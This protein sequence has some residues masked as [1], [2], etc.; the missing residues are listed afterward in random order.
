MPLRRRPIPFYCNSACSAFSAGSS[1]RYAEY[2]V[3]SGFT[4]R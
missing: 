4:L 2:V 3:L 1:Y